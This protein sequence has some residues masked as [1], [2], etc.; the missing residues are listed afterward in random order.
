MHTG[1]SR[2]ITRWGVVPLPSSV[3]RIQMCQQHCMHRS[4]DRH[5]DGR[6]V[7]ICHLPLPCSDPWAIGVLRALPGALHRLIR[8]SI[9]L[10]QLPEVIDEALDLAIALSLRE[11][12]CCVCV[13]C[14]STYARYCVR[15]CIEY[16]TRMIS[17]KANTRGTT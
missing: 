16:P 6:S 12:V 5:C 7:W 8:M 13:A 2:F 4:S 11:C 15:M 3:S 17:N 1:S 14:S 10:C 9:V